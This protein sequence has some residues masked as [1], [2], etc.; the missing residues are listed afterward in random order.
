MG[1]KGADGD[2]VAWWDGSDLACA[3]AGGEEKR[4][5]RLVGPD[6]KE[7]RVQPAR[8]AFVLESGGA[9]PGKDPAGLAA[10]GRRAAEAERL[11]RDLAAVADVALVWELAL[12]ESVTDLDTLADL[13]FETGA[14]PTFG[15]ARAAA[16]RA[17]LD[18]NLHFTR[19]GDAWLPRSRDQVEQLRSQREATERGEAERLEALEALAVAGRGEPM[20]AG[21]NPRLRRFLRAVEELALHDLAAPENVRTVAVEALKAAGIRYERPAEGAF[22]LLRALGKFASDDE[23]LAIVRYGLNPGF[24]E[25]VTRAARRAA[26]S[27]F[28]TGDRED[29]TGIEAVTID[30]PYTKEIDDAVSLES[31]GED[32]WRIGVHIADPG[33]FI[34]PDDAV[35]RDAQERAVTYFFPEIKLNMLP[36]VL[37]ELAASLVPGELRPAIS[38]LADVGADG[39]V[40]AWRVARTVIRSSARL[41]YDGV[42]RALDGGDGPWAV[43]LVEFDRL[44]AARQAARIQAGAVVFETP[45]VD[46]RVSADGRIGLERQEAGSRSRRLV[47]EAMVLAGSLAAEFCSERGL[48]AIYRRQAESELPP[49]AVGQVVR[50]PAAVRKVRRGLRRGE[51]GLQPG[52]HFALGLPGYAQATSPLRRYQDLATHRQIDSALRGIA[53][54]Y[55]EEALQ[56]IAASTERAEI[57]GRRAERDVNRFWLLRYLQENA[58][59]ALDAVV[60]ETTPRTVVLLEETLLEV[61]VPSVTGVEPGERVT[62]RMTHVNPRA[63]ILT[64][65]PA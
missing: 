56:R 55:E 39:E 24:P 43:L 7:T 23:N 51:A 30:S 35:D 29:L 58:D 19:K 14:A 52:R 37:G 17:F 2:L 32:G 6:G 46:V 4:R 10:A 41:D 16:V 62:L 64:L 1:R 13:A 26:E 22:K 21:E 5:L 11:V 12:D 27:G 53:P 45:E 60:L 25:E 28:E 33:A 40:G 18:D 42:D 48:P 50:E 47:A 38:F 65:R 8:V 57:E 59:T 36:P 54:V 15:I 61:P 20:E 44:A 9:C 31:L 49:E 34:A 3:V 63:D